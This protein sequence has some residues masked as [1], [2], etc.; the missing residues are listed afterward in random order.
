MPKAFRC[1]GATFCGEC[2]EALG[3]RDPLFGD[4]VV[5]SLNPLLI[6]PFQEL[7]VTL[8]MR[9]IIW[10]FVGAHINKFKPSSAGSHPFAMEWQV[11][12]GFIPSFSFLSTSVG[13][14][15]TAP[16]LRVQ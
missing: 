2:A 10:R 12:S 7:V 15:I 11:E 16:S 3:K 1:E 9:E 14:P 8:C 4:F 13:D 5:K 6:L